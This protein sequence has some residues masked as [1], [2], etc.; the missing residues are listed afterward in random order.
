MKYKLLSNY[1]IVNKFSL[2]LFTLIIILKA[3]INTILNFQL[4]ILRMN[5]V[6]Q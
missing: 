1:I 3:L 2:S 5:I 4:I 6:I